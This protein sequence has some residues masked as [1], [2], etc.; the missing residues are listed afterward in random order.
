MVAPDHPPQLYPGSF[1]RTGLCGTMIEGRL[2]IMG[3]YEDRIRQKLDREEDVF[4]SGA[5]LD[6]MSRIVQVDQW[7]LFSIIS[8]SPKTHRFSI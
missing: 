1:L 4:F 3:S 6:T 7:Y 8:P 5:I 2:F